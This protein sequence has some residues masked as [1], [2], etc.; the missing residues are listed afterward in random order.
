MNYCQNILLFLLS[1]S[2]SRRIILRSGEPPFSN[3]FFRRH[4]NTGKKR[5]SDFVL[6]LTRISEIITEHWARERGGGEARWNHLEHNADLLR[7]IPFSLFFSDRRI[8]VC[9]PVGVGVFPIDH[10]S[11]L[12]QNAKV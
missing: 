8:L 6:A 9:S 4:E 3:I 1:P 10:L 7:Y 5:A 12:S 11:L 2:G